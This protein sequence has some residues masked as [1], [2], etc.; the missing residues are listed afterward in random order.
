MTQSGAPDVRAAL[1]DA[2]AAVRA[3]ARLVPRCG[4]VLGS[5]L[6]GL[7]DEIDA[8]T[9]VPYSAIPHMPVPTAK[10]H[11][12]T[13]V[14][15]RLDGCAIA[16][17]S[18]R[19]HLYEGYTPADVVFAVRLLAALGAPVLILS[20]AAGGLNP[21]F[22][23]GDLMLLTDHLN[24]TGTNPL[25][26][27]NDERLGPRFPD[28]SQAYDR[29]LRRLAEEAGRAA[30]TPLRT[31]VYAGVLGPSYETP[32]EIRLIRALG[33]DAIGM[34]TVLETIAARHAAMRVLGIA[35]ITNASGGPGAAAADD[36][37]LSHEDVLAAAAA[38]GPRLVSVVR[39]VVRALPAGGGDAR[40][41]RE[42][43]RD[44]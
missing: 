39:S 21:E 5:G 24:L 34:S 40:V 33:A 6:G 15:G 22:H 35:V 23:R 32:A 26:G 30:G 18:G 7:A 17:L 4:I 1:H 12:G 41:P 37:S 43:R 16:A 42:T 20:N 10:G 29:R 9:V 36:R 38:V 31:G 27:P 14:L 25:V 8:E 3:H 13:L 2:A 11:A 44:G 28:M 19:V